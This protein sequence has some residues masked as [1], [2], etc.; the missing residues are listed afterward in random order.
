MT[1]NNILNTFFLAL[2][3][4]YGLLKVKFIFDSKSKSLITILLGRLIYS[5][6]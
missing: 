3:A 6:I 4:S 2:E 1:M 5:Y